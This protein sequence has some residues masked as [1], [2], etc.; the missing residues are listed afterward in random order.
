MYRGHAVLLALVVGASFLVWTC[1]GCNEVVCASMVSKCMLTQACKCD[2]T[3]SPENNCTCCRDCAKCLGYLYTECCSCLGEC[4]KPSVVNMCVTISSGESNF[5]SLQP[6]PSSPLRGLEG[7]MM[8]LS[9]SIAAKVNN[10]LP[11]ALK[12]AEPPLA[13]VLMIC[14]EARC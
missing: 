13:A 6:R 3:K 2:L 4:C 7:R 11:E 9:G 10:F 8:S 14:G 5:F 1:S 12:R